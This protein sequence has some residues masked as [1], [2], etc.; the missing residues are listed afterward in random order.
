MVVA[1]EVPKSISNAHDGSDI[2][3]ESPSQSDLGLGVLE[4]VYEARHNAPLIR[5]LRRALGSTRAEP[6]E[7]PGDNGELRLALMRGDSQRAYAL[8]EGLVRTSVMN[9]AL[10]GEDME[11]LLIEG[12]YAV[13]RAVELHEEHPEFW[14][15]PDVLIPFVVVR[16]IRKQR[17][18]PGFRCRWPSPPAGCGILHAQAVA[19]WYCR[20]RSGTVDKFQ[21]RKDKDI[22]INGHTQG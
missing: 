18:Y 11:N 16:Q 22:R 21:S 2:R 12:E 4:A 14:E 19:R 10:D 7:E 8:L 6:V 17:R 5:D 15:R 20:C 9:E 1:I 13:R 3:K